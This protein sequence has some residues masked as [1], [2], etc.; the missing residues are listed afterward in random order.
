MPRSPS[1]G[2]TGTEAG[3]L[4]DV[5]V[6]VTV[7]L[8]DGTALSAVWFEGRFDA[9]LHWWQ[10]PADPELTLFFAADRTPPAGRNINYFTDEGAIKFDAATGKFSADDAKMKAAVRKLDHELL[11]IEAEGSYEK[12]KAILD[13]YSLI[14]PEMKG[15]L[16]RLLEVPVDIEPI[17]PLAK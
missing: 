12:A 5:G 17:F 3:T 13:K 16:D 11:T 7:D 2:T 15:A 1:V 4:V 6:D 14:R 9:M 8:K 10:M